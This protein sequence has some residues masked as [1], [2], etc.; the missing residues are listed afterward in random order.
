M[1]PLTANKMAASCKINA[2]E[3]GEVRKEILYM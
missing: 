1:D 2:T 3:R